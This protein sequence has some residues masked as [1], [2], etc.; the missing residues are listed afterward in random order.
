MLNYVATST[1]CCACSTKDDVPAARQRRPALAAGRRLRAPFPHGLRHRTSASCSRLLAAV[2]VWWL[3]E[4][5]TIGFEL[6]AVGANPDASRTAGMN[7]GRGLHRSR[8]R[9]PARWP[10]WR[11]PAGPRPP[12]SLTDDVAGTVGFD[13]IT[14]AL[15][16]RGY[17]ARHRAG[18]AAV[19]RAE[20]RRSADA[21]SEPETPLTL[22]T[23]AAGADRAVRRGAGAGAR[24]F[25]LKERR[26]RHRPREGMGLDEHR[27]ADAAARG[28]AAG[29]S[30]TAPTCAG[31]SS[32]SVVMASWRRCCSAS[33][34]RSTTRRVQYILGSWSPRIPAARPADRARWSGLAF[35]VVGWS[36]WCS[37]R[38]TGSAAAGWRRWSSSLVGLLLRSASSCGPTPTRATFRSPT[39]SRARSRSPPR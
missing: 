34:W 24:V 16:G 6:R 15:L 23:G 11:P 38:S 21:G 28:R 27:R 17:A 26:S 5:S 7:V 31:R 13:A 30:G 22:T 10:G 2:F 12:D 9:S 1:C 37:P 25:R 8:W 14:V 19:R 20:R 3:L 32:S 4:R 35:A 36:R 33:R 18:R 29:T 39:R